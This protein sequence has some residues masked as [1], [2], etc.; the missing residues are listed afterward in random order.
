[1]ESSIS[2]K[3]AQI[4]SMDLLVGVLIFLGALLMFYKYSIN[5]M[6]FQGEEMDNLLLDAKLISSYLMSEGYPND[7]SESNVT[8][9]GITDGG[10]RIDEGK[11]QQFSSIAS[12]DYVRSRNLLST[13]HN[14]QVSFK[15]K[16]GNLTH[17]GGVSSIGKDYTV[18]N[19]DDLIRIERFAVYNSSIIRLVVYV[20]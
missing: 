9:M 4:W 17:I 13:I 15:D 2:T 18:E 5:T 8:L 11:V 7:W 16:D 19:P 12:S 10:V 1:M 3:K 14:Y 6:D 20:W